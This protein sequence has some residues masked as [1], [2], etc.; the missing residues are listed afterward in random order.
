MAAMKEAKDAYEVYELER[1]VLSKQE[2]RRG[3]ELSRWQG[4]EVGW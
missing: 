4:G 1:W 3:L 2:G